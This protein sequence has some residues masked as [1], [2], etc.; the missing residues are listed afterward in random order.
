MTFDEGHDT[1]NLIIQVVVAPVIALLGGLVWK[2]WNQ[3]RKLTARLL[4]L[5]GQADKPLGDDTIAGL[6]TDDTDPGISD[7]GSD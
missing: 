5:Q 4:K 2:L 3:N 6:S 1:I 7:D